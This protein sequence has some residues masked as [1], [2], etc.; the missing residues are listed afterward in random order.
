MG[1]DLE[2]LTELGIEIQNVSVA[3]FRFSD[4]IFEYICSIE[5]A[6]REAGNSKLKFGEHYGRS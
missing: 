2:R 3:E 5:V 4:E 1:L 6:H